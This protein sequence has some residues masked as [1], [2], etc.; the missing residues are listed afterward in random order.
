MYILI[1]TIAILLLL[2]LLVD[3]FT[4]WWLIGLVTDVLF[5]LRII[6]VTFSAKK[7]VVAEGIAAA[8]CLLWR[9]F[10]RNNPIHWLK[11]LVFIGAVLVKVILF[12]Y[13][14]AYYCYKTFDE[15]EE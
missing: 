12:M 9:M 3:G 10:I 5:C 14:D 7:L 2:Q 4:I 8:S 6:G 15:D 13:D 11:L 1:I